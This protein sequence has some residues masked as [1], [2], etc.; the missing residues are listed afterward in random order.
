MMKT[1]SLL[2]SVAL[3]FSLPITAL[4]S[5]PADAVL[6]EAEAFAQPGGWV[7][8]QQS[9][10]QMGSA[11]LL[12]HGLGVPVAD[13]TTAVAFQQ[14]GK[15]RL[16]VRTRDWV[17]PW[18]TAETHP[19][20][21]AE[22][23]PGIFQVIVDGKLVPVTFG[24]EGLEWHWQDGGVVEIAGKTA[25]IALRDLTGFAGRCDA[26]LFSPESAATPPPDDAATLAP[27]RSKLMRLPAQPKE[28]GEFDFVV[29]GG[30]AAGACAAVSAAR[31]GCKVALIHDRP[32]LGGN[33]SSEVRV[34][35]SGLIHQK[36]YPRL[37]N[38]LEELGPT[39]YWNL[40][41]AK[42]TPELPRSQQVIELFAQ[43]PQRRIHNAGPLANY[44]DEK[45]LEVVRAEKNVSLFLSTRANGVQMDGKRI[46]A[47][48]AQD[49][50]TG[51]R[52]RFKAALVA[53]C[54]GD[55][56]IGALA[57]ADFAYG[58]ESKE[59]H[60]ETF[61][62]EKADELVMGT[63]VQWNSEETVEPSPF[64]A[65]PWAL[66]F[67]A[68]HAINTK[69]GD[70]DWET[71]ALRNHVTEI[72]QIR[73]YGLRVVF[74]NWATLKNDPK[75]KDEFA[76]QKLSWVAY[77]GGKRESR[78]LLGDVVLRQQDIMEARPFPD[79]SVTTTWT[80]DL[81]YPLKPMC[82]CEAFKAEAKQVKFTPYAIPYRC[83]YSRNISNLMM[84]GRNI[85]VTHVAL[86]TVRVQRTTG[87]MGEVL[88]MASALCK[89]HATTPRGVYE[90]HLDELKTLMQRGVG[91][92]D[93]AA[94]TG[95]YRTTTPPARAAK[96]K[97]SADIYIVCGQSNAWRLGYVA[98]AKEGESGPG[99]Y[100]FG[101]ACTSQPETAR[102]QQ[103]EKISP[104]TYGSG[105]ASALRQ[106]GGR[107]VVLIQYA[108]CG[109][110]LKN[111]GGWFPGEQPDKGK[112]HDAG[113]YGSFSR[114]M[115][116][117]RREVEALGI[118]WKIKGLFWH[119]GESDVK[120][121]P[122]EHELNL[123][124]LFA[125]FR[126]DFGNE[127][128][129]V[130]GEIREVDDDARAMNRTLAAADAADALMIT[131]PAADLAFD[132]PSK[133]SPDKPNVHFSTQGCHAL[134]KRM[135]DAMMSLSPAPPPWNEVRAVPMRGGLRAFWNVA[136]GDN[137]T[138]YRE[139]AAHGFEMVDLLSTYSDY[140][141]RQKE[142]IR[143]TLDANTTNPWQKPEFFERI[144]K[145]N[146]EQRGNQN[147]IFVHDIEFSFEEDI[148]KVWADP[149][150]RAA[151]KTTTREQFADAYLREWATW[152]TLP[153]QWAKE[154]F[155]GTP[156]GIY[157]PQPF[158]RDYFGIAG[159]SAQQID[160]THRSDAELWQHIDP[161]V[162]YYIASIYVFYDKP[163]SV[164]YMAANVEENIERTRR[165]GSKPLYAYLWLRYHSSNGTLAGQEVAPWLAEAMA[166]LPYFSGARGIALW[167]SEPRRQGQ[168]YH[169]LPVFMNSL[170]RVSDLSEKIAAAKLMP[171]EP[172]HVLWKAKR[173]LIRR[174][175]VSADEW[176]VLAVNPWQA[177]DAVST[178]VV[179]LEN[180]SVDLEVRGRHT[181]IFHC[182][183]SNVKRL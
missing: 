108:V 33:N 114:Y 57:G 15:Y 9:M 158:R 140:P 106:A 12:A 173:P 56:V 42:K 99:L 145:R 143:K 81:H 148:D 49:I 100:Y 134:G 73:D 35:L 107:D 174:L 123:Q 31:L 34:G 8:D 61:A 88:G 152:F 127:L 1:R 50:K 54:T 97:K 69:R 156:I 80:I 176:I 180:G 52:L 13:A 70:W 96:P 119:Q 150:V 85:S 110:G 26:L 14:P 83:L 171:D 182:M 4:R 142:N 79:A 183:G 124:H 144:V 77:I 74:G 59:E 27:L 6:V 29:V 133:N 17:A 115:A 157:G 20:M 112:L 104:T 66:K 113:I 149:V 25:Q 130:A 94:T 155:P 126:Q 24:T 177:E 82:A 170:G 32:V 153:C 68:A 117:V 84:A 139:A 16:W 90:K 10:D 125:R 136:G 160:G 179:P 93:L 21:R 175:R 122:A 3:F 30:G 11:Y 138:N 38:L 41:Q 36:P 62:P 28:M 60:G 163:D 135:V 121:P 169:T 63:S 19:D 22:G 91:R 95:S 105:L 51:R 162:D 55:G 2:T 118:E 58:R 71:G 18:K 40:Q 53:D 78:R 44:E 165:Y 86:G 151:S 39:G 120:T 72:E 137:T 75:F 129:I 132:P 64:P 147:A 172:A 37:G 181:E 45:K 43:E 111:P 67:D 168:Y 65:C 101:M 46:A 48:M 7:M 116:D 47:V 161:F 103:I 102:L 109:S 146:I 76:R 87:M 167:G 164:Y 166:A 141:G 128:P 154:R 178:V 92:L 98:P 159:K 131:V 89:Q 5:A 23:T